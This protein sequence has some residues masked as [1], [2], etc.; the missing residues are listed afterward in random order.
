MRRYLASDIETR[1]RTEAGLTGSTAVTSTEILALIDTYYTELYD[2]LVSAYGHS[3]YRSTYTF[4]TV[5]G[6]SEYDTTTDLGGLDRDIL[7]IIGVDV[8]IDANT[9]VIPDPTDYFTVRAVLAAS[10]T[11]NP[12]RSQQFRPVYHWAGP[13]LILAPAPDAAYTAKVHYVPCAAKITAAG[14]KIDGCNGWERYIVVACLAALAKAEETDPSAYLM[15][16]ERLKNRIQSMASKRVADGPM[17]IVKR[18]GR[19]TGRFRHGIQ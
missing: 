17:Q 4:T 12:W 16:L 6:T 15:E 8:V 19:R 2:L 11:H 1:I 5:A 14:D 13:K 3:F 7:D 9:T 10:A 18:R